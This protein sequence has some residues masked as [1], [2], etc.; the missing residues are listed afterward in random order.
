MTRLNRK[1][2]SLRLKLMGI[3]L[4]FALIPFGVLGHFI[5]SQFS[6][7]LQENISGNL[8]LVVSNKRDTIDMFLNERISQLKNLA[9][10]Y[11]FRTITDTKRLARIFETIQSNSGSFIDLGI[12]DSMGNHAAYVGPYALHKFNYAR[13]SWFHKVMLKGVFISDVF[14]GFRNFPHFIIAVRR[15]EGERSWVLRATIDSDIFTTLVRSVQMGRKGDAF[16]VNTKRILQTKS[17]FAGPVLSETFLPVPAINNDVAVVEW[18]DRN[19]AM[20]AG[21]ARLRHTD[22]RLVVAQSPT[23]DISP[24]VKTQSITFGLIALGMLMVL[25]ASYLTTGSLLKKL[26][27]AEEEKARMDASVMQAN[28]MASL[29]KLATGVAHEINNPLTIIREGAGWIRDIITDGELGDS[30]A[31]DELVEA[32]NDIDRHVERARTV[33]HRMLGFARRMEPVQE[34]VDINALVRQ[35]ADFLKNEALHRNIEIVFHFD[36]ELPG[37]TTDANQ[38]QQVILNL[39]ENALDAITRDGILTVQT[40]EHKDYVQLSVTD[41]GPGIPKENLGKVFDPFFTTKPVGEGTGLGLSIIYSTMQR[42]GGN[43]TVNS[44][45]GQGATFTIT[46]PILPG[47]TE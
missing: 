32:V 10:S 27:Q 4:C 14:M 31:V 2:E 47:N 44:P 34:D 40:C 25:G 15:Q 30:P 29:G 39:M 42:L 12:I 3:T 43:V 23:E 35:T 38:L 8:R 20:I 45:P 13:E 36:D 26:M 19:D 24:L 17:R 37:I 5:H 28:K 16:L 21:V 11:D 6:T 46:L 41:S 9:Y 18:K 7:T 22:W 33:T 1:Y